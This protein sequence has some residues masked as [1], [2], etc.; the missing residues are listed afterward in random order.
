MRDVFEA[1]CIQMLIGPLLVLNIVEAANLVS[2]FRLFSFAQAGLFILQS[3]ATNKF[4][5]KLWVDFSRLKLTST[6][7]DV[8]L[9]TKRID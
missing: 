5:P 3:R 8:D 7:V 1:F 9:T 4:L 2:F 6:T